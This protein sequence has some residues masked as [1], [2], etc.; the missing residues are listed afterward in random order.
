MI[1]QEI[2]TEKLTEILSKIDS[3]VLLLTKIEQMDFSKNEWLNTQ[4]ASEFLKVT[5][6]SLHNYKERG[7][8]PFSISRGKLLFRKI[9]LEK[10]L[11]EHRV[12]AI[13]HKN[14]RI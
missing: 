13:S 10:Y 9:D 1:L 3:I 12:E 7:L 6:R 4:E 14:G 11:M 2:E 8:I 5:P